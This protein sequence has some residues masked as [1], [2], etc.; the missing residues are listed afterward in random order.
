MVMTKFFFLLFVIFS[1][2]LIASPIVV[3]LN[4]NGTIGP[5]SSAYLKNGIE[6]ATKQNAQMLLIKLDTASGLST[7]M[8][9]MIQDIANAKIPT[10]MYVHPKGLKSPNTDAYLLHI[11][12]MGAI[13]LS[14]HS[15][16]EL[17]SK[18]D[19]KHVMIA[20]ENVI[21]HTKKAIIIKYQADLKTEF[22]YAI[23]NPNI[24]YVLLLITIYGLFFELLNP[25]GIF[26][27]VT[28]AISGVLVLYAL[29][30]IPFNVAGLL[31]I[32]LGVGFMIAEIFVAGFGILG[33]GGVISF[34]IGSFLLFDANTLGSSVSISLIIAFT[35]VTIGF[36]ILVV[37]T[38]L[39]TRSAKIVTGIED[40]IGAKGHVI[41]VNE[42]DSH[43]WCQGEIWSATSPAKL[44]PKQE[45]EVVGLNG[46]TLDVKP[47]KE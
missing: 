19:G 36:F 26:P 18:L 43:V 6:T 20:G 3:E 14:T 15:T 45:I 31:L 39:R 35:L 25:G 22:L 29:N 44:T 34:A 10:I 38:L 8:Q 28:A 9:E 47:I 12:N 27:G 33:I 24:I 42:H 2:L 23:T 30:L 17:L 16:Q 46:L 40:I 37:R 4:I 11:S 5:A 41:D 32:L 13:D 7:S 1:S 21:L